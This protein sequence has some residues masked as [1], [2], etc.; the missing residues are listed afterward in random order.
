MAVAARKDESDYRYAS[1]ASATRVYVDSRAY[2]SSAAPKLE[3][4]EIEPFGEAE[5]PPARPA[6]KTRPAPMPRTSS[7]R[8]SAAAVFFKKA[9]VLLAVAFVAAALIGILMRYAQIAEEYDAVNDIREEISQCEIDLTELRVKL[10]GAVNIDEARSAAG[11][12]GMDYPTADQIVRV[13][14]E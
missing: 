12:A 13:N 10:N 3:P 1:A 8:A 2:R 14:G 6:V 4:R 7:K 9:A 5:Y 11:E